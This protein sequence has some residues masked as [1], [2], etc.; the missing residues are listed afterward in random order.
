MGAVG[1]GVIA[2]LASAVSTA[3]ANPTI[4]I[5][6]AIIGFICGILGVTSK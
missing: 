3:T 5:V 4:G 2:D 6:C 1:I